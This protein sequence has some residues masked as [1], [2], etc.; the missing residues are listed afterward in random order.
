M[1][2]I[3]SEYYKTGSLPEDIDH[4][5]LSEYLLSNAFP[6]DYIPVLDGY[7]SLRSVSPFP[8]GE[9]GCD[10]SIVEAARASHGR[11]IEDIGRDKKLID[12]LD[13][14]RHTTPFEHITFSFTIECP[15]FVAR[16]I[17]R[18]RTFSFNEISARYKEV[19]EHFYIPKTLN[20]QAK[21]NRQCSSTEEVELSDALRD[22]MRESCRQQFELYKRLLDNKVS[23]EQARIILP[24]GTY[25][26]FVVTANLKN[27]MHFLG[28][29]DAPDSQGE[30]QAYAKA[31]RSIIE[32]YTPLSSKK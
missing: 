12:Y 3:V 29:R 19:P 28:L 13:K 16:H 8:I 23:R 20:R 10:Y 25:T 31:I 9:Y 1:Q 30:T 4:R 32:K 15:I 18:H 26:T 17:M 14:N 27:W 6:N 2:D 7:V 21:S 5:Q 11:G 24:Q 22:A